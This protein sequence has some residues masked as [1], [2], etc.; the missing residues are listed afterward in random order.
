[1]AVQKRQLK[2]INIEKLNIINNLE[3]MPDWQLKYVCL[4]DLSKKLMSNNVNV[5]KKTVLWLSGSVWL[6]YSIEK[7]VITFE[8]TSESVI[9][10]GLIENGPPVGYPIQVL[11]SGPTLIPFIDLLMK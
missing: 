2:D 4:I 10:A 6:D 3:A 9:V 5:V 1:M 11:L 8:G 7:N